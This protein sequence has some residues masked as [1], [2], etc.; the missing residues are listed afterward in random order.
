M[1]LRC[2]HPDQVTEKSVEP[3][4]KAEKTESASPA[5]KA[6]PNK[7]TPGK[8]PGRPK[9]KGPEAN[10]DSSKPWEGLFEVSVKMDSSPPLLEFRDLREGS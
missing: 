9:K 8:K 2:Y 5:A 1:A 4:A 6:T 10:G 3:S 7:S